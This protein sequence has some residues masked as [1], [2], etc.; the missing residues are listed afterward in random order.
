MKN[1][2]H[3][4]L[5]ARKLL[6]DLNKL[7]VP[8]DVAALIK[9]QSITLVEL[10][11]ENPD[12]S[13]AIIKSGG[14]SLIVVNFKDSESR[15]RFTMAHELGHHFLHH[16]QDVFVD[17]T[18]SL[19]VHY[20]KKQHAYDKHEVEANVFAAELLMPEELVRKDFSSLFSSFK[21]SLGRVAGDQ[22][23]FITKAL[24]EKYH[25]SMEAMRIRIEQVNT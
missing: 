17:R 22:I 6:G 20:R 13:G 3:A 14:K 4:V 21:S 19:S 2:D 8:V 7:R 5:A 24:A 18:N 12:L 23:E 10:P 9:A 11:H 16:S 15:K 1:H 25:V